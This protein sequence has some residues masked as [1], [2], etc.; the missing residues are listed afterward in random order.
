[1]ANLIKDMNKDDRLKKLRAMKAA[2]ALPMPDPMIGYEQGGQ[3]KERIAPAVLEPTTPATEDEKPQTSGEVQP[4]HEPAKDTAST[5][6]AVEAD[7]S[8]PNE[9]Q[10]SATEGHET[11]DHPSSAGRA[12]PRMK[13]DVMLVKLTY[14]FS[15]VHAKRAEAIAQHLGVKPEI[16]L[17]KTIQAVVLE[18]EDFR[19]G[20]EDRRAGPLVRRDLKVPKDKAEAWIAAQDPLGV[21]PR[22]GVVLR[23][24]AYNALDRAAEKVLP[25]LEAKKRNAS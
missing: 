12:K 20:G 3:T 9:D 7:N 16:I 14:R 17:L 24:V 6:P 1:M 13:E 15:E 18:D 25:Q 19:E 5:A 8:V 21:I 10:A 11:T 2:E 22:P 23:Q 4:V